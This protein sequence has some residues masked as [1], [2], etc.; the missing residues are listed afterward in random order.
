MAQHIRVVWKDSFTFEGS[1]Y[2]HRKIAIEGYGKGW[3]I[4]IEGDDNIYKT[5]ESARNAIDKALG[6]EGMK[7]A[8]KGRAE[9]GIIIIGK[10]TAG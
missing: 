5:R 7:R 3:T 10:K 9:E 2:I 1:K 8:A 6:K 4:N